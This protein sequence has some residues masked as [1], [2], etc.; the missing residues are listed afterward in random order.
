MTTQVKQLLRVESAEA[1]LG[2]HWFVARDY[3]LE[4]EG[5]QC[6]I[7]L[8]GVRQT[9]FE[10]SDPRVRDHKLVRSTNYQFL[11]EEKK[12]D[13][14]RACEWGQIRRAYDNPAGPIIMK[15]PAHVCQAVFVGEDSP[16]NST[17]QLAN[18]DVGVQWHQG[19]HYSTLAMLEG[20][21]PRDEISIVHA[22]TVAERYEMLADGSVAAA[23]LMEPWITLAEKRGFKRIIETHY[24]GV[25]NASRDLVEDVETWSKVQRAL[26]RAVSLINEDKSRYVH[27]LIEEMPAKYQSEMSPDDFHLPRLRYADPGEYRPE[28]FE[29]VYDWMLSWNLVGPNADYSEL[30]C[31]VVSG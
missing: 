3:T 4:D 8:P 14:Y 26:R 12:V 21:L 28:E 17:V 1:V 10:M 23:T 9:R 24:Q 7:H 18:K 22:G 5:I 20:F 6:E 27:Y 2:L 25:E 16:V 15:R 29:R 31:N 30:V 11:F 19:S 13:V